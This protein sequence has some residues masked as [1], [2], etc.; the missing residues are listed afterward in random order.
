[1]GLVVQLMTIHLQVLEIFA[2]AQAAHIQRVFDRIAKADDECRAHSAVWQAVY[3]RD[4][5]LDNRI[6]TTARAVAWQKA[7]PGRVRKIRRRYYLANRVEI[8]ALARKRRH[9]K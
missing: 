3:A 8:L 7:N 2:E 5:Y 9:G 6:K 1:M 4:N